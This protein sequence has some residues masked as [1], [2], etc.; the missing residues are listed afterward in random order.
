[1]GSHFQDINLYCLGVYAISKTGSKGRSKYSTV[2][3]VV[4]VVVVVVVQEQLELQQNFTSNNVEYLFLY[5][6]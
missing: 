5:F 6:I 1:M 2:V 4:L 3:V